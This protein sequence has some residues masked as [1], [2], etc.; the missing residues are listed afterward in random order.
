MMRRNLMFF[1]HQFPGSRR[2]PTRFGQGVAW[3][4]VALLGVLS[5]LAA[6]PEAHEFFHPEAAACSTCG[7]AHES[8]ASP[9]GR[10]DE[11]HCIVTAFAAGGTDLAIL[12]V[13]VLLGLRLLAHLAPGI[14]VVTRATPR[15][16]HAP[17]CG[18]PARA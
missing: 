1:R 11:H 8:D 9:T 3:L 17:S 13:F 4:A 7:H 2:R 14:D 5:W 15:S 6:D 10:A 16:R 18:P 12:A